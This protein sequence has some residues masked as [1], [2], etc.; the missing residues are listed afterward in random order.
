MRYVNQKI[1][2]SIFIAISIGFSK[3]L[4]LREADSMKH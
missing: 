3:E 1:P 2:V 4:I